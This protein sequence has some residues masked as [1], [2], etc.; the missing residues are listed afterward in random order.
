MGLRTV[1]QGNGECTSAG[2][3]ETE[4]WSSPT[5]YTEPLIATVLGQVSGV[6]CRSS[7]HTNKSSECHRWLQGSQGQS[8]S[9]QQ[10][11]ASMQW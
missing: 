5:K 8:C 1:L 11:E 7:V 10:T 9:Q 2:Q 6:R 4:I 3:T